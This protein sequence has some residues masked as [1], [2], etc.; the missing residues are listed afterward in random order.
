MQVITKGL[1]ALALGMVGLAAAQTVPA[2]ATLPDQ[3]VEGSREYP[4]YQATR[5]GTALRSDVPLLETPASVTVLT[6]E[7]I[8]DQNALLVTDLYRNIASVSE[9]SYSGVSFRGFR[10]E[11]VRYNGVI[12]DPYAGFDVPTLW[13]IQQVEALKGP[14]TVMYG[15]ANPGGLINY[16]TKAPSAVASERLSFTVGQFGQRLGTVEV[17]GPMAGREDT[18]YRLGTFYEDSEGFRNGTQFDRL[19]VTGAVSHDLSADTRLTLELESINFDLAGHRLRGVPVD[20]RGRFRVDTA[21]NVAEPSDRQQ[22][23]SDVAQL[24]LDQRIGAVQLDATLRFVDV[25]AL[26]NY[27]EPFRYLNYTE[28]DPLTNEVRMITRQYRDQ[29]R[30]E[31]SLASVINAQW[32]SR[33]GGLEQAWVAG[34]DFA[35]LEGGLVNG[36]VNP[37]T[38]PDDFD[39][40]TDSPTRCTGGPLPI[41]LFK[42]QYGLTSP[43]DYGDFAADARVSGSEQDRL[44]LY[45]QQQLKLTPDLQLLLGLRYDQFEDTVLP[46]GVTFDDSALSL[47]GGLNYLVR[48]NISLYGVAAQGFVP[49]SVGDQAPDNGGP[50]DPIDSTL[51]ELGSKSEWLQGRLL[52]TASLFQIT[53]TN[54]LQSADDPDNPDLQRAVGEVESQG[55]ELEVQGRPTPRLN[56]LMAYAY[57]DV[58]I[59]KDRDPTQ[60]GQDFPNT[61]DHQLGVFARYELREG[62]AVGV[63]VDYIDER[64]GFDPRD[65]SPAYTVADVSYYRTIGALDLALGIK[66]VFDREYAVSSFTSRGVLAAFPGEPRNWYATVTYHFNGQ[67]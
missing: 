33:I 17:T 59:S 1:G 4:R 16:V 23:K 54:I 9:F 21:F 25:E 52:V 13:T 65:A 62:T 3:E 30:T 10:Q 48:P 63:G 20:E 5:A 8:E 66:N 60:V 47:R 41:D 64:T 46:S 51:Y 34:V 22:L 43:A 28:G 50:F 35:Q 42:P 44:G 56:L 36:I 40:V 19:H 2:P 29:D 31:R 55:F 38:C 67:R 6:R 14:A 32:Q 26:Q 15:P 18:R 27:H 49:Q 58:K 57:N 45:L 61:P 39:P 53:Q 12:G 37:A 7:L 11:D 24:R